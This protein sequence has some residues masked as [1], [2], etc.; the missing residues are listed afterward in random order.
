[1]F[2]ELKETMDKKKTRKMIHEQHENINKVTE[3][4]KGTKY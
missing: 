1:M 3:V 2:K 4:I